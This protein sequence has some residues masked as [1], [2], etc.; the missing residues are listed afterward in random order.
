MNSRVKERIQIVQARPKIN[1]PRLGTIQSIS[2]TGLAVVDFPGNPL[3]PQIAR[4]ASSIDAARLADWQRQSVSVLLLF[5]DSD[6]SRPIIVEAVPSV[7]DAASSQ[8]PRR[9]REKGERPA[10][11]PAVE[12]GRMA[13]T[14]GRLV[15]IE[16]NVALVETGS[17]VPQRARTAVS[18]RNLKD[19]VVI[20]DAGPDGPVI[21]GQVFADIP[22]SFEVGTGADL[23]LKGSRVTIE[24]EV[25]LV[26]KAGSSTVRLESKG[27]ASTTADQ[28]VS[29]ARVANKVR[30]GSVQL[31]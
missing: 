2:S 17:G 20:V 25:E 5:E 4:S 14:I 16:A 7:S 31:N 1:G 21:I 9:P 28:I 18:L 6:A 12:S 30:G 15:G 19:P 24:A 29:T 27:K 10:A 23:M 26:L 3:G 22:G 13:V 11:V 8:T